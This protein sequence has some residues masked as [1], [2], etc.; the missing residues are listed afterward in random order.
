MGLTLSGKDSENHRLIIQIMNLIDLCDISDIV[1]PQQKGP[2]LQMIRLAYIARLLNYDRLCPHILADINKEDREN[3]DANR[4]IT[5]EMQKKG[6]RDFYEDMPAGKQKNKLKARM[7]K[8]YILLI[9]FGEG[10]KCFCV[11]YL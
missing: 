10:N 11:K 5:K 3:F 4:E 2:I 7:S 6:Q 9:E 8:T 1:T